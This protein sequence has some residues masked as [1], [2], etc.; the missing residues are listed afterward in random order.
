MC[1]AKVKARKIALTWGIEKTVGS[2]L[3]DTDGSRV[4]YD[5]AG[6]RVTCSEDRDDDSGGRNDQDM[7]LICF[8]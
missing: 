3:P 4:K 6:G 8:V 2:R 5:P 1:R 7:Y